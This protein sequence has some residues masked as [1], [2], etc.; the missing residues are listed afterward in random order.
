MW[1]LQRQM[2]RMSHQ[3]GRSSWLLSC[4]LSYS[5]ITAVTSSLGDSS[6]L[7]EKLLD[8]LS[9]VVGTRNFSFLGLFVRCILWKGVT[10]CGCL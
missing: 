6:P 7:V 3:G 5:C 8:K 9:I 1:A 2:E 10:F 4:R